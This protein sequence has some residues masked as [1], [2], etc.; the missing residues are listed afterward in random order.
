MKNKGKINVVLDMLM[1]AVMLAIFCV[2]G[3][4][5]EAL[6]YTIGSM[7]IL[8]IVL[9]WPQIKALCRQF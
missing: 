9:H 4:I 8:H 2:K 3:E 7:L 6:A 5:H 1:F